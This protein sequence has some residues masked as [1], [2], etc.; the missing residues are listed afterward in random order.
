MKQLFI[1]QICVSNPRKV[2][3]GVSSRCFSSYEK[4]VAFLHDSDFML[5]PESGLWHNGATEAWI[6]KRFVH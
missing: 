2:A 4:A 3:D 5:F 1:Y 6:V